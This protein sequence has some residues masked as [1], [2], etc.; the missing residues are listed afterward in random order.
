MSEKLRNTLLKNYYNK[1]VQN[2][3]KS[4]QSKSGMEDVKQVWHYIKLTRFAKTYLCLIATL[5]EF[6]TDSEFKL[7]YRIFK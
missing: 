5:F 2:R 3:P 1:T 4:V 7:L 6:I